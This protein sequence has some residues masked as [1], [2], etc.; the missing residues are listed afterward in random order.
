M[1][2][3]LIAHQ[4]IS[5]KSL[6][7]PTLILFVVNVQGA[8][9]KITYPKAVQQRQTRNAQA[10]VSAL[11]E[12]TVSIRALPHQIPIAHPAPHVYKDNIHLPVALSTIIQRVQIA[13]CAI[14]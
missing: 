13:Q 3:A 2:P 1:Y 4:V 11:L 10:V 5:S 9:V 14:V 7:Q 6:V 8:P 12:P